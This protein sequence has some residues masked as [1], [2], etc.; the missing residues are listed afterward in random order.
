MPSHLHTHDISCQELLASIGDY[1]EGDLAPELCREIERHLAECEHC[2]V[3]VDTLNKTIT[4]YHASAHEIILP[5]DVR[6][7]LYYV[8]KL[9]DLRPKRP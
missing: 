8:L 9:D 1:V 7:R 5:D 2:R 6:G 4:L 3:V